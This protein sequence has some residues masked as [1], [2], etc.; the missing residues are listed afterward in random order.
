MAPELKSR[1]DYDDYAA[2]PADGRRWEL[3]DGEPHVTPAPSPIHQRLVAGLL[4]ALLKHFPR[5]AEVF[6]SPID[7][8]LTPHDVLQPDIVV[9]A[10]PAQVSARG[11][12][13]PPLLVVE[14]LSPGTAAYDRTIKARRYA[15]LG[16][17]HLWLV[18]PEGR[19]IECHRRDGDEYRLVIAAGPADTLVHP[20]FAALAIPLAP[21][22]E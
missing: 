8:I 22:W 4:V 16:V 11:I 9:V 3:L 10:D 14:V 7:V 19:S 1:L 21:L 20:D 18:D 15:A 5:P 17:P 13:G 6:V 12:E 2:I